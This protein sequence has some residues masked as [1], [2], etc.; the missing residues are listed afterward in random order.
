MIMHINNALHRLGNKA[1][2]FHYDTKGAAAV[3]FVFIAT[4][5]ITLYLG[6]QQI[7]L[8]LNMNKKV[9]RAAASISELVSRANEENIPRTDLRDI[10]QIGAAMLQPYAKT[11][12]TV[13]VT[14]IVIDAAGTTKVGFSQKLENGTS[15]SAPF[16][17]GSA[18]TVP[19]ALIVNDTFLVKVDVEL[20]YQLIT[21]WR[22]GV[23]RDG[24]GHVRI[25][26]KE[27]Y[28]MRAR[29]RDLLTCNDC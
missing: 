14:G 16:A 3:E 25:P 6:T 27:T 29:N 24:D 19:A 26:M 10:M 1:K 2:A 13:T 22:S 8:S 20:R 5:L 18:I 21:S 12:P 11:T 7:S 23:A 15:Y 17:K 9:G 28:Y 4:L